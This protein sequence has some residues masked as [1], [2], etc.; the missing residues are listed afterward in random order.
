[1]I[2]RSIECEN[3]GRYQQQTFELRRGM[4][5]IVG[6]NEAGKSTLVEAIPAGMC[7]LLGGGLS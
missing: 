1:M 2:L 7:G 5:L 3:F 4:N 6:P